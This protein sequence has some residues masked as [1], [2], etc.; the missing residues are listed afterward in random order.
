MHTPKRLFLQKPNFPSRSQLL[1]H[2]L[3]TLR[4]RRL[5]TPSVIRTRRHLVLQWYRRR[6]AIHLLLDVGTELD[7]LVEI[8]DVAGDVVVGFEGEGDEGHEADCEPLP[9]S[10]LSLVNP[11][12]S[13]VRWG[14]CVGETLPSFGDFAAEVAAVLALH[15]DVLVACEEGLEG[16]GWLVW[17]SCDR[18][19]MRAN[20][21]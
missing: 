1:I 20:V 21:L 9:A 10:S 19:G 13:S 12:C 11:P 14:G 15:C 7:V 4:R 5:S 2:R 6:T 8:A 17:R 3:S 16:W 18:F